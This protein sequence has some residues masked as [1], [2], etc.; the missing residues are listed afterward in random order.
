MA[1]N[2]SKRVLKRERLRDYVAAFVLAGLDEHVGAEL[3][4]FAERVR[5]YDSGEI[6]REKIRA[7]LARYAARWPERHFWLA[8]DID[9]KMQP[10]SRFR[11]TFPLRYEL[12]NGTKHLRGT[13]RKTLLLEVRGDDLQIV[14]VNETQA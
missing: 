1:G 11:V 2:N 3:E 8:G 4:F 13:V 9:V 6:D 10:D 14:A 12:A 7:D 5:Y